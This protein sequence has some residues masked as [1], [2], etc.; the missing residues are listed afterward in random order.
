MSQEN[1]IKALEGVRKARMRIRDLKTEATLGL[2]ILEVL[3]DPEASGL[4]RDLPEKLT[5]TAY[6]LLQDHPELDFAT[7]LQDLEDQEARAVEVAREAVRPLP[8]GVSA[9]GLKSW[10]TEGG[11]KYTFDIPLLTNLGLGTL[12]VGGRPLIRTQAVVDETV[13]KAAVEQKLINE[14]ALVEAKGVFIQPKTRRT[15]LT[16]LEDG[17]EDE[18]A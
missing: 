12:Q 9:Y 16:E 10:S 5:Q 4:P 17:G 11:S 7:Q 3:S 2:A 15:F 1:V 6:Q 14:R 13:W 8:E 18:E